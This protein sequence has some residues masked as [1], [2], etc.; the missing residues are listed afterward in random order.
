MNFITLNRVVN[1]ST[2]AVDTYEMDI[3]VKDIVAFHDGHI[4]VSAHQFHVVESR[5]DIHDRIREAGTTW[6]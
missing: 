3:R 1:K 2:V 4:V 5:R 6:E